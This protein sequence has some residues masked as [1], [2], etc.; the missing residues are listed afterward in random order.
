[1]PVNFVFGGRNKLLGKGNIPTP[2]LIVFICSTSNNELDD[3]C[4][5][6]QMI[7]VGYFVVKYSCNNNILQKT[8]ILGDILMSLVYY[9]S[10]I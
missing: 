1:M 10:D 7:W 8:N 9:C 2:K 5:Y 4:F 3:E 6:I